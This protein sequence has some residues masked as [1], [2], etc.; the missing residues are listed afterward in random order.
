VKENGTQYFVDIADPR[1]RGALLNLDAQQTNLV[2]GFMRGVNRMLSLVNTSLNPEFVLGNFTRDLETAMGNLVGEQ[3][4]KGGLALDT[5]G[6]KR[7]VIKDVLPSIGQFYKG[8]RRS[9][10]LDPKTQKLFDEYRSSGAKTDWYHPTS[11]TE[12]AKSIETLSQ[13]AQGTFKGNTKAGWAAVTNLVSDV[14]SAV[15]NGVRFATFK[16]AKELFVKNGMPEKLAIAQAAT[17]A[18]NLTV[19]FNRKGNSG[20]I[21]NALYLF[22]N[23]SVQGTAN[24]VRGIRSSRKKQALLTAMVSWGALLTLINEEVSEE[25]DETG[26]TY[27]DGIDDY[28]KERNMIFMKTMNPLY[29]GDPKLF[30]KIPLPYGYN[31]LHVFGLNVMESLLGHKSK[32][33]AATDLVA[34]AIGSFAPIGFSSS[35]RGAVTRG[36]MAATPQLFKPF[37]EILANE[38][39]F[40]GPIYRENMDFGTQLPRSS[41]SLKSTPEWLKTTAEFLNEISATDGHK[42]K[43]GY[44]D[45]SPD[46]VAHLMRTF[47][48]G[49]GKFIERSAKS[50]AA[51]SDYA[52]DEYREGDLSINDVPLLRRVM[53]EATSRESQSDYYD[54]RDDIKSMYAYVRS[55]ELKGAERTKYIAENRDYLRLKGFIDAMDKRLAG[56]NKRLRVITERILETPSMPITLRLQNEQERLEDLKTQVYD[57]FNKRFDALIGRDK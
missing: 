1:L 13:M 31:V 42:Y 49:S 25:D 37:A 27:Y 47:T 10:N 32:E 26:R 43:S 54:R 29:K 12:S 52:R 44:V 36:L 28:Q 7:G 34:A 17:L 18:K 21:L 53:G 14:N 2:L 15:E 5:K 23:A 38:N 35:E 3:S 45:I 55:G 6:L 50:I 16:K 30:Y 22:F 48:G 41:L 33:E 51:L 56:L 20:E 19:N 40:G 24:F 11:P 57:R 46:Q 8:I 4:M 39:F 9:K